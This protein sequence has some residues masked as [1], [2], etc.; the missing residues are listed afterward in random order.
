M[1]CTRLVPAML[2]AAMLAL[3]GAAQA[4]DE[5]FEF[6]LNPSFDFAIDEINRIEIETGQRLRSASDSRAD[7]YFL[8]GWLH[9][10][11]DR[12]LVLSGA[13][14]QR[15]NHGGLDEVRT[16]Q[17]IYGRKGHWR[18]RLRFEQRWI[19]DQSRMGLRLRPR[20][21]VELPLGKEAD[22]TFR[23]DGEMFFTLR[24]AL[25]GPEDEAGFTALRTRL[26]FN[27]R[28]SDHLQLGIGYLRQ[29]DIRE[30]A[31][32]RIS[33]APLVTLAYSF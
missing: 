1:H 3:P 13:V 11:I 30:G 9:H 20:V 22:W 18:L 24:S 4:S 19:E 12:D 6:W 27:Y 29:Q 33:H 2:G 31:P 25:A 32:D 28:A 23:A 14:E 17:Q 7:T 26:G 5:A 21:G 10:P 16:T 8:R 15:E